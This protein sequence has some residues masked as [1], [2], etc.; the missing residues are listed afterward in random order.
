M[1]RFPD[2]GLRASVIAAYPD[3]WDHVSEISERNEG[4]NRL[5]KFLKT[6]DPVGS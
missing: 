5:T 3:C 4:W 6:W 1:G 2:N